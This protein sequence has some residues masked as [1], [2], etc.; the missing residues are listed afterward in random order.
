VKILGIDPGTR[1]TGYAV[2]SVS[3]SDVK[4]NTVGV[5]NAPEEKLAD[6]FLHVVR[7]VEAIISEQ[8]PDAVVVEASYWG[9]GAQSSM[10]VAEVRGAIIAAAAGKGL[11]V[12]EITPAEVKKGV[13]G[14]GQASKEQVEFMVKR[15]LGIGG[16][17]SPSDASDALA[18]A[19][20]YSN[21]IGSGGAVG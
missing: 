8:R 15:I 19:I 17:I 12:D 7:G 13:V 9:R 2:V 5:I 16:R 20:A 6:R 14:R 1:T 3:G 18:I 4:L 11:P 21:R 10:K